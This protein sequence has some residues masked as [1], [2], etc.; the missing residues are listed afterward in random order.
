MYKE[1]WLKVIFVNTENKTQTPLDHCSNPRSETSTFTGS[2]MCSWIK[3]AST[4]IS[5]V[6]C[7]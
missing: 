7:E 5:H 4:Y 6:H 1:L 3:I 2:E